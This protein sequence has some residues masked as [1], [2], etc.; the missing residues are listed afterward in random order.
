M[1]KLQYYRIVLTAVHTWMSSEVPSQPRSCFPPVFGCAPSGTSLVCAG[2]VPV[3]RL[4]VLVVTQ[5]AVR[6]YVAS[7]PT[8]LAHVEAGRVVSISFAPAALPSHCW[9][10]Q[11]E[12]NSR[13]I[14]TK[15]ADYHYPISTN[16]LHK[17]LGVLE[18]IILLQGRLH[19]L[20]LGLV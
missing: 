20:I 14:L 4:R 5:F 17:T 10:R 6:I 19:L 13:I 12:S 16:L 8:V 7:T 15:D 11:R 2:V 18:P 1:V 3:V 9:G